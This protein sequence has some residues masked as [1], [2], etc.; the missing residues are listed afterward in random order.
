MADEFDG[1]PKSVICEGSRQIQKQI[2]RAV[3]DVRPDAVNL[4]HKIQQQGSAD[5]CV[6]V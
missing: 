5:G 2:S 6:K 3:L 1:I 4:H